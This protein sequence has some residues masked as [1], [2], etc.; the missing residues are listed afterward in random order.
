MRVSHRQTPYNR[1][2]ITIEFSLFLSTLKFKYY[3]IFSN[4][5]VQSRLQ[6][7][8][9]SHPLYSKLRVSV[10]S[11][12]LTSFTL[13]LPFPQHK[14]YLHSSTKMNLWSTLT[15]FIMRS[16]NYFTNLVHK[17]Q[18]RVSPLVCLLQADG[19]IFLK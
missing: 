7:P 17:D 3:F 13:S 1:P 14:L 19:R 4:A 5:L 10:T 18:D 11:P 12:P 9:N 6:T 15:S 8:R 2:L 16:F